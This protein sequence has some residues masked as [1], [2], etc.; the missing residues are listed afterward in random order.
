[1]RT[2][3]RAAIPRLVRQLRR[4]RPAR[5]VVVGHGD[6][7]GSCRYNDGL[8]LRRAQA[9]RRALLSAG[10]STRRIE[11]ASLGERRPLDFGS[12]REAHDLNRRVEILIESTDPAPDAPPASPRIAPACGSVAP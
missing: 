5:I 6:H 8:A 12:T 4:E 10:L 1:M 11:V 2:P 7:E 9:V 3:V